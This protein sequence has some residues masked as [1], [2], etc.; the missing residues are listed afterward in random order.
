M[1]AKVSY[2]L[3][4]RPV[5]EKDAQFETS[6]LCEQVDIAAII[7]IHGSFEESDKRDSPECCLGYQRL[8]SSD[9]CGSILP[10]S[11]RVEL[12]TNDLHSQECFDLKKLHTAL[13]TIDAKVE[14]CKS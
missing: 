7:K 11:D 2:N 3:L 14:I 12:L 10:N 1:S 4:T 13:L 5:L 9:P 6:A 8:L